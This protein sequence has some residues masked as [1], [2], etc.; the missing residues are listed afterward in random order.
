MPAGAFFAASGLLRKLPEWGARNF[1]HTPYIDGQ[2]GE[3]YDTYQMTKDGFMLLVMG[4]LKG[5]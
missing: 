5:N 2:N 1:A 4:F 3:A